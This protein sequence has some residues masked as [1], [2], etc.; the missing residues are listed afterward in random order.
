MKTIKI[1]WNSEYAPSA[2]LE[3]TNSDLS[4]S[5]I[6]ICEMLFRDTNLY[7]G[8][9]WDAVK[10]RLPEDRTHTALSVGDVVAVDGAEYLCEHVGWSR[11]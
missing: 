9:L 2:S 5:D 7:E 10:D 8:S 11:I 4:H 3:F 6:D 1:T